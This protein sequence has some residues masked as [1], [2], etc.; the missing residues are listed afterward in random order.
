MDARPSQEGAPASTPISDD[1]DT[2]ALVQQLVS[3]IDSESRAQEVIDKAKDLSQEETQLLVDILSRTLNRPNATACNHTHAWHSLVRIASSANIFSRNCTINSQNITPNVEESPDVY[4]VKSE[5]PRKVKVLRRS[6]KVSPRRYSDELISWAHLS[7]RN[8][9]P[10]YAAFLEDENHPYLVSPTVPQIN[11]LDH[12]RKVTEQ[13]RISLVSDVANGLCYMH[14]LN[15]IHGGLI[16]EV[17]LISSEGRALITVL[18]TASWGQ[19]FD[20]LPVRYS[21]PEILEEDDARPTKATDVWSFACLGYEALSGKEPYFQYSKD[22]RV[23]AAIT[24]GDKPLRPGQEDV[25]GDE[26]NG[27]M[28]RLLLMCWEHGPG[29]RP[30]G[31]RIQEMLSNMSLEDDRPVPAL[32]LDSEILNDSAIETERAENILTRIFGFKQPS[33]LEIPENLYRLISR[34]VDDSSKRQAVAAAAKKLSSEETQIFVDF[35]ELIAKDIPVDNIRLSNPFVGLLSSIMTS[36]HVLPQFYRSNVVRYDPA[37]QIAEGPNAKAYKGRGVS[38]RVNVVTDSGNTATQIVKWS[39]HWANL[40]HPNILPFCGVFHEGVNDSPRICVVSPLLMNGNL[41]DYAPTLPPE[42]RI[43]LLFDVI[44]G[45]I[46]MHTTMSNSL[47]GLSGQKVLISNE[48]RAMIATFG[49]QHIFVEGRD[50]NSYRPYSLRFKAPSAPERDGYGRDVWS[51]GCLCYEVATRK[52]PYYQYP[53]DHRVVTGNAESELPLRP[54]HAD[55]DIDQIDDQ[56]W[57]LITKCCARDPED[58]PDCSEIQEMIVKLITEDSR[59]AAKPLLA[60]EVLALRSRPNVDFDCVEALLGNIQIELLRSPLSKLVE[61]RTRAVAEAIAEL[62]RG[63]V[64]CIVDFLDQ[65]LK[66][67]LSISD[68]RNRVLALLSKITSY[69]H[70]FPRRY[71]IKSVKYSPKPIAEG[72][73]GTVYQGTETSMC[74]KVMKRLDSG[75]LTPWVKELILWAHSSHP[76][77]LPFYGVFLEGPSDS[78]L[79]CLVSLFMKNGNLHDYAP[80]LPQKSRLPLISDVVSGLYYLHDLGVVHGDLKGQ[81]ILISDEG[82]GLITDFGA[83]HITTATAA[84]GSLSATTLRFSAPEMILGNKKPSKEFDIWS[85]GC[86]FY[87]VLSR[88]VPYHEYKMEVQIIAALSRKEPPSRPGTVADDTEEKD[89]WDDDFDQDWDT[90]DDQA[91][92]L[93]MKCCT[94]EPESRPDIESVK[95]LVIDLKIWDDRPAAKTIPGAEILKLRSEPKLDLNRVEELIEQVHLKMDDRNESTSPTK[96]EMDPL[97]S[98]QESPTPASDKQDAF[99]SV[100]TLVS[101]IDSE[102]RAQELVEKAKDLDAGELQLLVDAL[103]MEM[104]PLPSH[105]ESPTPASD[106]QDAFASVQTLVSRIDSESRAQEL[107]EK[108]KDLD[109]GELQLLVDALSMV[110]EGR[111][112][113]SQP[114]PHTRRSLVKIASF[115]KI[116]SRTRTINSERTVPAPETATTADVYV[117]QSKKPQRVRVLRQGGR[118]ASGVHSEKLVGWAHL[119]HPNI[120]PLYATFVENEDNICVVSPSTVSVSVC[121]HA[122]SLPSEQRIPLEVVLVSDD[123]RALIT[124]FDLT[125]GSEDSISPPVRYLAPE[126]LSGEDDTPTKATDIWS[127]ACLF[128]EILLTMEIPIGFPEAKAIIDFEVLNR[129]T[130]NLQ[131][132]R[133]ILERA[134]GSDQP[135]SLQIPEHLRSALLRLAR[136]STNTNSQKVARGAVTAAK[137]LSHDNSQVLVDALDLVIKESPSVHLP[138]DFETVLSE[139]MVSTHICPQCYQLPRLQYDHETP[140]EKGVYAVAYKCNGFKIRVNVVTDSSTVRT[141]VKWSV[142]WANSSHPNV[143]PFYGLFHDNSD[144]YSRICVVSPLLDYKNLRDYAPTLPQKSRISLI[145]DVINGLTYLQTHLDISTGGLHGVCHKILI[146]DEGRALI[147]SFGSQYIFAEE[148]SSNSYQAY[149]ERFMAPERPNR[150]GP[151]RDTWSFGCLCYEV[152]SRKVPYYQYPDDHPVVTDNA[153]NELPSRPDCTNNEMDEINDEAWDL[154]AKCCA[155]NPGDQPDFPQIQE[156]VANLGVEDNHPP[157]KPLPGSEVLALR[158]RADV[159]FQ[160]VETVLGQI[161]VELLRSPLAKLVKN[162][163]RDVTATVEEFDHDDIRVIVDFLDQALKAHLSISEERNRVLALLS[164]ITSLTHIFPQRYELQGIKHGPRRYIAE[165]GCGTVYQ[166]ADPTICIKV[167]KH[168]DSGALAPWIK[169]VILWAHSS[170]PNI[171]PFLGVFLE[172]PS[173][174]PQTCLISPFMKNGNLHDYAPRLPQKSRLP[175][176]S[177]V[178]DGLHY[179]HGLGVVHGDLKGQNVLISDEGRGL[180]TDFGA[181]HITTASAATGTLAS[182]TL[183]FTAPETVKG[184]RKPTKEYDIWSLGCLCYEVVSR[185]LPYYEYT[186]DVQVFAALNRNEPLKRPGPIKSD[187]KDDWDDDF[188]LSDWDTIDDQTWNLIMTCCAPEPEDRPTILVVKELVVDLKIWDDRPMVKIVP[189]AEILKLRSDP[190]IDASRVEELLEQMQQKAAAHVEA[191]SPDE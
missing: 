180:I 88:K 129:S 53:D 137:K 62:E 184:N 183:R 82:R 44:N 66:D 136:D 146:S 179:L 28:W 30:D 174:S 151:K 167:M 2:F 29:D 73:F 55:D 9:L 99:A 182:T 173:G 38:V 109:A 164:K 5:T 40:S 71:E 172:G 145:F 139:V 111:D 97:P 154:I 165:G 100:Q 170:H 143:L 41:R 108:A 77:V 148:E 12:A 81:N 92:S 132:A 118:D 43:P 50:F 57:E 96:Q 48:G 190:K 159:D 119:P 161:Q 101:R 135:S 186:L 134:L 155:R 187:E 76:N 34:L 141:I 114:P 166:G 85:V 4:T 83:A 122:R 91:W 67:H 26:I 52:A 178:A 86:L 117:V 74:I 177:D 175:L 42:S 162:R 171:L 58:Q 10:L 27:D 47:G 13:Q 123:G 107:V 7:H 115:A 68:E 128:Y 3:Q 54:E 21:A 116:F 79:T 168:L 15:I 95:E 127:L 158:F 61:N 65:A 140:V 169:E 104:D 11:I 133:A 98:H 35:L 90:I 93:I 32:T 36:T 60:P 157:A 24:R 106:K 8:I 188:G 51:F 72:G 149:Y 17:V 176:I 56:L 23:S 102:S 80:R 46:Y 124:G 18:D 20:S 64:R 181:S 6:N 150:S 49:A 189:G 84:S 125:T 105:Q 152:L 59:P 191:G 130:I 87:E 78:P 120:L 144:E 1:S 16:P 156:M 142:H 45:L 70:I 94:P 33:T 113:L 153:D 112:A 63:D 37:A 103:S 22:S 89:D 14:Q 160:Q 131:H 19:E 147:A 39:V 110:L 121:D 31:S 69:T 185:K 25:R 138:T 163:T 75:A 126:L